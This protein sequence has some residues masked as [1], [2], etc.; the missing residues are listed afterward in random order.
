M[1]LRMKKATI[2]VLIVAELGLAAIFAA[3]QRGVFGGNGG[4]IG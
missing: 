3:A 2:A 1:E 4:A